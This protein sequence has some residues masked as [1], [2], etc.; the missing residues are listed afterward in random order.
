MS[1]VLTG[2][3]SNCFYENPIPIIFGAFPTDSGAIPSTYVEVKFYSIPY[4]K[5]TSI[6]NTGSVYQN[7]ETFRNYTL[8]SYKGTLFKNPFTYKWTI[9]N[10]SK[11][12]P[13]ALFPKIGGYI[14]NPF[15]NDVNG[16]CVWQ[17]SPTNHVGSNAVISAYRIYKNNGTWYFGFGADF[18]YY[19]NFG[20]NTSIN[21]TSLPSRSLYTRTIPGPTSGDLTTSPVSACYCSQKLSLVTSGDVFNIDNISGLPPSGGTFNAVFAMT[22]DLFKK[23]FSCTMANEFYERDDTLPDLDYLEDPSDY[24][25]MLGVYRC[26]YYM[27][28]WGHNHYY[29]GLGSIV[30]S[31][32][33]NSNI[34]RFIGFNQTIATSE[35]STVTNYLHIPPEQSDNNSQNVP[36]QGLLLG[37]TYDKETPKWIVQLINTS[38]NDT[39]EYFKNG[40]VFIVEGE[41][42]NPTTYKKFWYYDPPVDSGTVPKFFNGSMKTNNSEWIN[43]YTFTYVDLDVDSSE[44]NITLTP[45]GFTRKN[46]YELFLEG[47]YNITKKRWSIQTKLENIDYKVFV[48]NWVTPQVGRINYEQN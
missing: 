18:P 46:P 11:V 38:F 3:L 43:E 13:S 40:R 5:D 16:Y 7:Y 25:E 15:V 21:D 23:T 30:L 31:E 32:S 9:Y 8:G 28:L 47:S 22:D 17:S 44:P 41:E 24:E 2:L 45:I 19:Q 6:Y 12:P 1:E 34:G 14:F 29:C 10:S 39:T 26:N 35:T 20:Y 48:G 27:P 37:G 36:S 4:F 33:L 42:K